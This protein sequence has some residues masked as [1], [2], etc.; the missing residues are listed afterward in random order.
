MG[1]V[2]LQRAATKL[3]FVRQNQ[4]RLDGVT[5][6]LFYSHRMKTSARLPSIVPLNV[7]TQPI[8]GYIIHVRKKKRAKKRTF[9]R[10]LCLVDLDLKI[11]NEKE[12]IKQGRKI[13]ILF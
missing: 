7:P 4:K 1:N 10:I 13:Y 8:K 6:S 3:E 12:A 2:E 9:C 5:S 11:K